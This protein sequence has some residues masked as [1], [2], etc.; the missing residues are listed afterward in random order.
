[1]TW[2]VALILAAAGLTPFLWRVAGRR[3]AWWLALF[4]GA[5]FAWLA[6][7]VP[8]VDVGQI[9]REVQPWVPG[10][11]VS[12]AFQLDGLGLLFALL[13]TG[14]GVVVLV[15]AGAYFAGDARQPR[16]LLLLLLFMASM[17]G[18]VLADDLILLFVFWELTSLT[19]YLLVGYDHEKPGAR[20]AALQALLVT[21]G[22]GLVLLA[23]ILMLGSMAGTFRVSAML[24]QAGALRAHPLYPGALALIVVGAMTKSAQVPFHFWLPGAMAAP[25]PVSAYLHSATMVKAGVYLLARL[26]GVLGGTDAWH[27]GLAIPGALTMIVGAVMALGQDDLKRLLAYTTVCALGTV[28]LLLG[29]DTVPATKAAMVFILVHGLYKGSL[30]LVAGT[31]DHEAGTRALSRLG[32]LAR[33]MPITATVAVLGALSMAGLPPL[34]GFIGKELLYEAKTQAPTAAAFV[35]GAGVTANALIVTAAALVGLVPFFGRRRDAP[36]HAHEGPVAMWAG[37]LALALC[38]LL[39][40]VAPGATVEPL[41]NAAVT[42][43]RAEPTSI[44]LKLWHGVN[45]ILLL[46]VFT[47]LAGLAVFRARALVSRA[48]AALAP[49]TAAGPAAA[50]VTGL[51]L[52]LR[53][54][55]A[56]TAWVQNGRLSHYVRT[57]IATFTLAVFWVMVSR[58]LIVW[59]TASWPRPLELGLLLL[60]IAGAAVAARVASRF[61]AI[62]ALGVVGCGVALSFLVW[63]GPDLALTQF[64][65]ETLSVLLFVFVVRLLPRGRPSSTWAGRVPALLVAGA[66]GAVITVLV[67]A[68]LA[69]PHDA[70][71]KQYFAQASVP[72]GKGRN[73]V[74]VILVD[75][76]GFDTLGEITV[77]AVAALGVHA[78]MR[79]KP[80]EEEP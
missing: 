18:L 71:L 24:D 58:R 8:T 9:V 42:A 23:G 41:V 19:S 12:L 20:A 59:P 51:D 35:T 69:A 50:Y 11:G 64:A 65:I 44:T 22:G 2:T 31:L 29:L 45:P 80:D 49:L 63:S 47:V 72:G 27:Y 75:F 67:W 30:F 60:L 76:R 25:S 21:G 37:P 53:G 54:A 78:L 6:A 52:L 5:V 74:N 28:T 26:A 39:F 79:L 7:R 38:G 43:V 34:F 68:V 15:Y 66:G 32:G 3:T 33:A 55:R 62:V 17:L 70:P 14:M 4:P 16:V 10:L 56:H 36:R 1:M 73:V 57:S 40:G 13:V 77:L 61:A 48:G 46:S